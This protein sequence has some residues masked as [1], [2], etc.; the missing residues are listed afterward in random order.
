MMVPT[1]GITGFEREISSSRP[2]RK[3]DVLVEGAG[4]ADL[5]LQPPRKF[6]CQI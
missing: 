1:S 6:V 4:G 5:A 2:Y 3:F